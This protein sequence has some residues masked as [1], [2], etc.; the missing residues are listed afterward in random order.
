[1]RKSVTVL[2][3][4]LLIGVAI[5]SLLAKT[6]RYTYPN[7]THTEVYPNWGP[8]EYY[9]EAVRV[10]YTSDNSWTV[11]QELETIDV[12]GATLRQN[13]QQKGTARVYSVATGELLD[14]R[15]FI[16]H[17]RDIDEGIDAGSWDGTWYVAWGREF[18][19]LE[20]LHYEW[21]I[22]GVYH[23]R[24]EARNGV[25]TI[26]TYWAHKMAPPNK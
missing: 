5:S 19:K 20:E 4:I 17:E 24:A 25:Y 18:S 13:L 23:F 16:C 2:L 1:M 15:R 7:W 11:N 26:Y 12:E 14:T 10:E 21:K 9:G 22:P 8:A 3:G 6:T